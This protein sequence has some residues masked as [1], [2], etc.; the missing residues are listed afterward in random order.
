MEEILTQDKLTRVVGVAPWIAGLGFFQDKLLNVI[1][2]QYLFNDADQSQPT[3]LSAVRI[4]VV[5]GEKE[6]FGLKVS[7]LIG[8]RHVW[9]DAVD[10]A[11]P[12]NAIW[13]HYVEQ[14][15]RMGDQVLPV[16]QL[17]QLVREMES[18]GTPL[19]DAL[20][21]EPATVR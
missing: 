7:E 13:S 15:I 1:D 2:G 5:Q 20:M 21:P 17:K 4:L 3:L 11:P 16:L 18:S 6:W 14:W 12:D 19:P 9:S 10:V 8:I